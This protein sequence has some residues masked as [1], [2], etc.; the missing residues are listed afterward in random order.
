[1]PAVK[2]AV[3]PQVLTLLQSSLFQGQALRSVLNFLGVLVEQ[4][5]A[6]GVALPHGRTVVLHE[7]R[8]RERELTSTAAAACVDK[9]RV[10]RRVDRAVVVPAAV[11]KL[12]ADRSMARHCKE[13]AVDLQRSP[14]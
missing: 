13:A 3:M 1:M 9:Q 14:H 12:S 7:Q 8:L 11:G 2:A 10:A 4:V 5:A 6:D